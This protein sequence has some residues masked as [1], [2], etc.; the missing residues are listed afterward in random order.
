[1]RVRTAIAIVTG[2]IAVKAILTWAAVNAWASY[3]ERPTAGPPWHI[4]L[5]N[6]ADWGAAVATFA[7]AVAALFIATRDRK[8]RERERPPS[9]A[10]LSPLR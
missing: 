2:F 4:E 9:E 5:G 3:R 10:S 7:A 6:V 8:E 1:M